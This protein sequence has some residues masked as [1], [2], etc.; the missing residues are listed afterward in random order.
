VPFTTYFYRAK[1]LN[2]VGWGY[3][4]STSFSSIPI[5]PPINFA[6][7]PNGELTWL[8]DEDATGTLIVR[9]TSGY[10]ADDE[11]GV[12]IYSG[13]GITTIDQNPNPDS[14]TY[15]YTAW[16]YNGI[17]FSQ[18]TSSAQN[19]GLAVTMI[20]NA[21]WFLGLAI[22]AVALTSVG[23]ATRRPLIAVMGGLFWLLAG[24][25]AYTLST[26][27]WDIYYGMAFGCLI[28]TIV[29]MFAPVALREKTQALDEVMVLSDTQRFNNE[30]AEMNMSLHSMGNY[31]LP[32]ERRDEDSESLRKYIQ[33]RRNEK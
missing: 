31:Q 11:D 25:Y 2:A 14:V 30:M 21:T 3:S 32:P 8:R 24:I 26:T 12:T 7:S 17:Y 18:A 4:A 20:G 13:V 6:V 29:A 16:G 19:G 5:H 23:Y 33:N 27:A 28:F 10:P 9:G 22:I 15:Y 1:A